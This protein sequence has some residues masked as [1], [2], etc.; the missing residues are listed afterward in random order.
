MN[1]YYKNTHWLFAIFIATIIVFAASCSKKQNECPDGDADYYAAL[2][3]SPPVTNTNTNTKSA[4]T[5]DWCEEERTALETGVADSTA[6]ANDVR[7]GF[8]AMPAADATYLGNRYWQDFNLWPLPIEDLVD[9]T[10][11]HRAITE[12]WWKLFGDPLPVPED[13]L[14]R[15]LYIN[16]GYYLEQC[17]TMPILRYNYTDCLN[18]VGIDEWYWNDWGGPCGDGE[19]VLIKAN[20]R[21]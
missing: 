5:E 1:I 15:Q 6:Y 17:D 12:G 14:F 20:G 2:K 8:R 13:S 9:S 21:P 16:G 3:K 10:I 19:W 4:A 7:A 18:N 11:V